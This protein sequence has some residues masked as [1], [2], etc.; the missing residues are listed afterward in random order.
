MKVNQIVSAVLLGLA[1]GAQPIFG[2]NYGS[3]QKSRVKLAYHIIL[4][5]STIM[6]ILEFLVFQFA[7]MS[8]VRLFGSESELY[9]EF[10]VKCF[11]IFLLA[12]P[13]NGLQMATGI[14]FQAIGKPTQATVLS[15]S[16]QIVY[17][18]PATLLLPM[19]LGVEGALWAGPLADVL[20]FITTLVMLKLYWEKFKRYSSMRGK[21][22][23]ISRQ[24]GSGGHSIGSKLAK[25]LDVLF[26]DKEIIE[27]GHQRKGVQSNKISA[28]SFTISRICF[29]S[30]IIVISAYFSYR[31]ILSS[32]RDFRVCPFFIETPRCSRSPSLFSIS[33]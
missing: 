19:S 1:T 30:Q 6:L 18:L 9:N 26:Y 27:I 32:Y 17:L 11:R 23:T 16:R 3:G 10:A 2:Y 4:T 13:I 20:A 29:P 14:F 21:I 22:I 7:P 5:V 31:G 25:G 24:C 8:I 33:S 28:I 15:L 12:C